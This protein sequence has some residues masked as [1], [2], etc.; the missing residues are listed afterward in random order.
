MRE[1][2]VFLKLLLI[3][4]IFSLSC[5]N[6]DAVF[7]DCGGVVSIQYEVES[8]SYAATLD[9]GQEANLK[10][11]ER[12]YCLFRTDRAKVDVC[13]S[14]DGTYTMTI[15]NIPSKGTSKYPDGTI[16][17]DQNVTYSKAVVE[18]GEVKI[19][20]ASGGLLIS[21]KDVDNVVAD[22]QKLVE[23]I[24]NFSPFQSGELDKLVHVLKAQGYEAQESEDNKYVSWKQKNLVTGGYS[25]NVIDKKTG[26]L[27]GI[28]EY[29][30]QGAKTAKMM[31]GVEQKGK[32]IDL[33]RYL[34]MEFFTSPISNVKMTRVYQSVYENFKLSMR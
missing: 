3:T 2:G 29:D 14:K 1:K 30:S 19:Y 25:I 12:A 21:E 16:G 32:S 27:A 13:Y 8:T 6:E 9:K 26:F 24:K 7:S 15:E 33:K 4:V 17:I 23:N 18:N 20:D 5:N 31:I 11:I 10:P 28:Q 34:L 22:N